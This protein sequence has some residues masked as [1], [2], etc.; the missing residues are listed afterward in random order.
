MAAQHAQTNRYEQCVFVLFSFPINLLL[1][2]MFLFFSSSLCVCVCVLFPFS[3]TLTF[4]QFLAGLTGSFPRRLCTAAE[5]KFYFNAF[6]LSSGNN[7]R[8]NINCNTSA[9]VSGCEPGWAC[10]V[11]EN[12]DVDLQNSHEIPRRTHECDTCCEGFFCPHGLTCMIRKFFSL[13]TENATIIVS[14]FTNEN[15]AL[16]K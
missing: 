14:N 7:L 5:L 16:V 9:W 11:L 13:L 10:S 1:H 15:V 4:V 2:C 6:V 3:Q 12:Q 8:P